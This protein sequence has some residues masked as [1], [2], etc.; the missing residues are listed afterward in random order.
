MVGDCERFSRKLS[1][2]KAE[3]SPSL[4]SF[5]PTCSFVVDNH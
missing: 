5:L 4:Q 3:L 2:T 1:A